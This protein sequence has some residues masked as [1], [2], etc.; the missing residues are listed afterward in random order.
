MKFYILFYTVF[1]IYLIHAVKSESISQ[2]VPDEHGP[3]K[4][5]VSGSGSSATT[6]RES[7][8]TVTTAD[9]RIVV[10][11]SSATTAVVSNSLIY[12]SVIISYMLNSYYFI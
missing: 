2:V 4:N 7:T 11:E 8:T 1:I 3:F 12:C 5:H 6:Y 9:G 10:S